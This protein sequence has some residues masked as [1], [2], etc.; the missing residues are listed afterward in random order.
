VRPF[1]KTRAAAEYAALHAR[2]DLVRVRAAALL[3]ELAACEATLAGGNGRH[4]RQPAAAAAGLLRGLVIAVRDLAGPAW[5]EA[6]A[7]DPD[8]AA[9]TAM[10]ATASP[11]DP[12]VIDETCS[13]V[14]WAR[15]SP[16]PSRSQ[17]TA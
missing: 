6:S 5:V 7:D 12:R 8:V 9:F 10:Q 1:S 15:F 11:P 16:S 14:L 3:Q 4:G 17:G 2:A 13:R